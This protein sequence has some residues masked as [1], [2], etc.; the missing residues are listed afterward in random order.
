MDQ[1]D[2]A[3]EAPLLSSTEKKRLSVEEQEELEEERLSLTKV[4]ENQSS[5]PMCHSHGVGLRSNAILLRW[6]SVLAQ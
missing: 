2:A 6:L 5:N 1:R 4:E 3:Q